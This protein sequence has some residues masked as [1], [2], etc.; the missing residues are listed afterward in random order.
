MKVG[1]KVLRTP[2]TFSDYDPKANKSS[3]HPMRGTVVYIHPLGRY[4]TVEFEL[5]GGKVRESF[6]GVSD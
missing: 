6:L 5:P 1:D 4:H 2:Q 3:S